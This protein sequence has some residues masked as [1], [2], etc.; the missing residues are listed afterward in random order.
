MYTLQPTQKTTRHTYTFCQGDHVAVNCNKYDDRPLI[1]KITALDYS[2]NN[3]TTEWYVGT[4][5]GTWKQWRGRKDGKAVIFT[6]VIPFKNILTKVHFTKSMRLPSE[7][8][9]TVKDLY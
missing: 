3:A 5:S 2:T 6:D 4:Y 7:I 1:G 9:S 8:I